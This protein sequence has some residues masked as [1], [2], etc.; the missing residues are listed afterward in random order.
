MGIVIAT[1]FFGYTEP[2]HA[3]TNGI[4]AEVYNCQGYNN[5]PPRPCYN[6][7]SVINN[8][9]VSQ[10]NFQWGSGNVLSN[11]SED[12]EVK[13]TG[14]IM[15]QTTKTVTFYAPGDDGVHFTLNNQVLINDWYDK[16]GGGSTSQ[17]ITLQANTGYPFTLWYYENGGGA[18]VWLYWTENQTQTLVPSSV[19]YLTDPTPPPPPPP[20][21]NPPTSLSL[22]HENNGVTLSWTAPQPTVANTAVERYAIS[23]STSSFTTNGWGV[24]SE[25][26]HV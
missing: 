6:G 24:R 9:T 7:N 12:V 25:E 15:S 16:G 18:N 21:L 3:A 14:Y 2:A 5:A 10:I 1:S 19:F 20:S 26:H 23:W 11:R 4:N 8:T 22:I 17:Q 13:F